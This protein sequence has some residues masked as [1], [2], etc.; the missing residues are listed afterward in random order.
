MLSDADTPGADGADGGVSES[1]SGTCDNFNSSTP[2]PNGSTSASAAGASADLPVSSLLL[3][4][5]LLPFGYGG[6]AKGESVSPGRPEE[7]N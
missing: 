4:L 2:R 7:G 3:L 1:S 5:L 6:D